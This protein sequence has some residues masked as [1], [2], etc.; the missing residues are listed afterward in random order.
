ML[1][2]VISISIPEKVNLLNN[3]DYFNDAVTHVANDVMDCISKKYF[4]TCDI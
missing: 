3:L 1:F 2:N 4:I